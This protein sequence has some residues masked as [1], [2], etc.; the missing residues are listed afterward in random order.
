MSEE[1]AAQP[2]D[3]EQDSPSES[4]EYDGPDP[5][6]DRRGDSADEDQGT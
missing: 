1:E 3:P 6:A 2:S 4:S 5:E